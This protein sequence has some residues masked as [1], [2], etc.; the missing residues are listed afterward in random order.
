VKNKF[1]NIAFNLPVSSLFTYSIPE[2]FAEQID[3]GFRVLAPFGKRNIT[4]M[5]MGFTDKTSLKTVRHLIKPLDDEPSLSSEMLEFCTWMSSY[6]FCPVGEVVFSAVPRGTQVESRVTYSL[7]SAIELSKEKLTP[8]QFDVIDALGNKKLTIKQIEKKLSTKNIRSAVN[9]LTERGILLSRHLTSS[10]KGKQKFEK[11]VVFDLLEEFQDFTAENLEIFMSENKIKSTCQRKAINYLR[12]NAV[13]EISLA[14]LVKKTGSTPYSINSLAKKEVIKIESRPVS[15]EIE[16]E[17]GLDAKIKELNTEQKEVLEEINSSVNKNEFKAF[18][19]FGVTGSGKTQVYIEAINNSLSQNKTAIVLVPEI[20]LTPQ[21]IH[22]FR[23]YFGD[24]IGVI[25]SRLTE[26][27]RFD[28]YRRIRGKETKIVIGARSALF[29]PLENIGIIMVDEEH[30]HSYKQTEKNP[31]YN[32][33]DSAI[34]RAKLNNAVVVLGSAT[35]SLESYYN[36]KAGKY[37]LLELPH[38]ALKTKQPEVEIVDMI[39]ELKSSSKFVKYETPEKRFLSSKLISYI[40][41]SLKN[42][43]SIILLQNR[44]GYSAYSEC[45][46]CSNVKMCVNCDITLIYHKMKDHLRCHYCGHIEQVPEKCEKCGSNNLLLKGTGTE[47]V[48]EEIQRLFPTARLRRMDADTVKGKDAHRK[49]L[50]SFHDGEFDILIGTQMIS[51]GLDFPNVYLVGV[52]SADIGL[53]NPDF[54]SHER[55]FQLLMQVSGR[56]GRAGDHG[57]VIIQT[58]QRDNYLFQYVIRND[59]TGFFDK[60]IS[61]RRNFNYPPFSRMTIIEISS[62]DASR[63]NSIASKIY[64]QL[65]EAL[66]RAKNDKN[67]QA[68]EIMKP[69]QALIYKIRNRYRYHIILKSLKSHKDS[70][71]ITDYLLRTLAKYLELNKLKSSERVDIDVDPVSFS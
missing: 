68:V 35:P 67:N 14:E 36:Y 37:H 10:E 71:A 12:S 59:F 58:M 52:I 48:E 20:S 44:R 34:V 15:R 42:K 69:A 66:K 6:Y 16:H 41:Q 50:K 24:I 25:H 5:V 17:F 60:E 9:S 30:D 56:S 54:R 53:M 61:S 63:S 33:R 57:R 64:L 40:D 13:K 28:V 22:R 27:Q 29:A 19:L 11:Y 51:K 1:A 46:D 70:P 49:I 43:Q 18:L 39:D 31:K 23:T 47:K 2:E 32:A 55:T 65:R 62:P 45:Q 26:G 7:N 8:L 3:C 38:R 4:G 21:L